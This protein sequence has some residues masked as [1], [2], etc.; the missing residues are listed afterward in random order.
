MASRE[1]KHIMR[2]E[3]PRGV[4]TGPGRTIALIQPLWRPKGRA[5]SDP[6]DLDAL[7]Q[8]VADAHGADLVV[9]PESYPWYTVPDPKDRARLLWD[10]VEHWP[11]GFA[12]EKLHA[13][14]RRHGRAIIAGGVLREDGVLR[15]A[16]L[17]AIPGR[18]RVQVYYK[19]IL[20]DR[21]EEE[22]FAPWPLTESTVFKHGD[23][24]I[25]PLICADVFGPTAA[26]DQRR[27]GMRDEV[28]R[29]AIADA[30]RWP[31]A[32]IVVCAYAGDPTGDDW[33]SRLQALADAADT[34]VL[35]CN[36]AGNDG[37]GFGGGNSGVF[38]PRAILGHETKRLED[39]PGIFYFVD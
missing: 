21:L 25:I 28:Q 3:S 15:N 18:A 1:G 13:V 5:K 24:A 8:H 32:P 33:T 26:T 30:A 10:P 11:I 23:R 14:A 7:D 29:I 27:P 38:V 6:W 12:Q 2:Y 39:D 31:G 37:G 36:V 16:L 19:R 4:K 20:W 17:C 34:H 22:N 9:F 35:F